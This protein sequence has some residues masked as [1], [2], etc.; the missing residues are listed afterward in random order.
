MTGSNHTSRNTPGVSIFPAKDEEY[1]TNWRTKLVHIVT[2]DREIDKSPKIQ[3]QK[4]TFS[5]DYVYIMLGH[6]C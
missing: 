5:S 2:K 1:S 6:Q 3:I 4:L